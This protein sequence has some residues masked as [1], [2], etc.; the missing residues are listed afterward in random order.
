MKKTIIIAIVLTIGGHAYAQKN[1]YFGINFIAQKTTLF[2]KEDLHK[3]KGD[4]DLNLKY[5][6][7]TNF[8]SKGLALG[9]TFT[10]YWGLEVNVISS[11]Q[12]QKYSGIMGD[13]SDPS[14]YSRLVALET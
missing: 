13:S 9:Y 5:H 14:N 1:L 8:N 12:G 7:P 11:Y 6:N 2:N 10:P 3:D 4:P